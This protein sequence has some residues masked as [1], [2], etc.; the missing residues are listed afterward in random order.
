[1]VG[2]YLFLTACIFA[3]SAKGP[4][5]VMEGNRFFSDCGPVVSAQREQ[6]EHVFVLV[7]PLSQREQDYL[8][9]FL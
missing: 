3:R 1:M 6:N 8:R 5:E 4:M 9:A 2:D 7:V